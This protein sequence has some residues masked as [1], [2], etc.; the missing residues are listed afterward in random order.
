[1]DDPAVGPGHRRS[2]AFLR[3]NYLAEWLTVG[4]HPAEAGQ[5]VERD[6]PAIARWVAEDWP[7]IKGGQEHAH[8]VLIDESGF[9]LQQSHAAPGPPGGVRRY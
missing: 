7:R 1:M 6:E 2:T 5:A 8:L 3:P 9:F 4:L